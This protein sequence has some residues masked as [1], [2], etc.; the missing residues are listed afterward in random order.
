V[1]T[2]ADRGPVKP[3]HELSLAAGILETIGKLVPQA[4]AVREVHVTVGPLAGVSAEALEFGFGELARQ[5]GFAHARLVIATPGVKLRC[6]GC[7]AQ[8]ESGFPPGPCPACGSAENAILS[9][10]EFTL[11]SIEVED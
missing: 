4:A 7:G 9:G 10:T 3:M 2:A 11:D 1:T 6:S 8:R 5:D